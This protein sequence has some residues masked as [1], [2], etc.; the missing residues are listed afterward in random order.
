MGYKKA[1]I[2]TSYTYILPEEN[3]RDG[4]N[5]RDHADAVILRQTAPRRGA[6]RRGSQQRPLP[7]IRERATQGGLKVCR[8]ARPR[9]DHLT[10]HAPPPPAGKQ[11][12][13]LRRRRSAFSG[14]T[15]T[16]VECRCHSPT[17]EPRET[18]DWYRLVGS[19]TPRGWGSLFWLNGWE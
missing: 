17:P 14:V 6:D 5:R 18:N 12:C 11:A 19:P 10:D 4:W 15:L 9:G 13:R 1:T 8:P 3:T 7:L 2:S 16:L